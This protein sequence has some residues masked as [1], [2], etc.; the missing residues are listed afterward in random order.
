MKWKKAM[1][2]LLVVCMVFT[3]VGMIPALGVE[4]TSDNQNVTSSEAENPTGDSSDTSLS[5]TVEDIGEP[6]DQ[7]DFSP[8]IKDTAEKGTVTVN[9]LPEQAEAAKRAAKA[10]TA[11]AAANS[12]DVVYVS[13]QGNDD[14]GAGTVESPVATLSKAVGVASKNA[15][16]YV[17]SDLT[18][19]ESASYY[20]KNLTITSYNGTFTVTR[21]EGFAP[22]QDSARS[23]YNPAMIEVNSTEGPKTASLKL[24]NIVFDDSAKYEGEYF[25]QA[26]SE[27]DGHTTVGSKEVQNTAIVQDGIIATYNNVG[28]ITLG[29]G[30]VLKNYGGMSAVRIASGELIMEAGSQIIDEKEITRVKGATG[31]FGPAGAVW[32]QGGIL[33]MNGGVIGGA[34]N[35]V[36]T[37]RAVYV[38]GGTANV[39]GTLQNLKGTDAAWQGQNGVA[40][41]LRSG[42]EA[43]LASTGKINNVTGNNAGNNTAIWT[44][45]CNFTTEAGSLISQVNGFQMLHFDDLTDK[46]DYIHKVYL[47]GTISDCNSGSAC[48]LRSWY[49]LIELGENG[50]IEN[51]KT[52]CDGGLLYSNN[53]TH[54]IIR[55]TIRNNES[56]KVIFG[57]ITGPNAMIYM[58]NQ[59]GG[60]PECT[61]ESTARIIDNS[62]LG[63]RVNNG[64]LV[65]M[66]GGE[67]SGNSS[68]G[69][70]VTGKADRKGVKFIMNDG[71]IANNESYGISYT[72]AGESLVE[73]NGGSIYGNNG[74]NG[75]QISASGGYAVAENGDEAGYE[76]THIA[77]GVMNDSRRI[78][79]SA[80]TVILPVGYED[81]N[82]GRATTAAENEIKAGVAKEHADWTAIGSS[83]LWIQPSTEEYGFE[84]D[85]I[86]TVKKTGLYVAYIP[87][88]KDGTPVDGAEVI[89]E[90]VENDE[91]V[92]ITLKNLTAG[93]P[94][95]VMLFNNAEYIFNPDD[96][97]VY[98]GGGQGDE[99]YDDGFPEITLTNCVDTSFVKNPVTGKYGYDLKSLEVKGEVYTATAEESLLDQLIGLLKVS[100]TD[101]DGKPVEDD[102][103]AGE[104]TAKLSWKDDLKDEDVKVNGNEVKLGEGGSV[105]VRHIDDIDGAQNG[106]IT[107]E[108]LTEE[109]TQPVTHAEAIAK[110]G[111]LG[112]AP[113]FYTNNDEDREADAEGVQLLD[114]GLLLEEDDNRQE[115]M[116]QKAAE[117]L[118]APEEGRA[119]RYDFHYLDLVD[120]FNGNAWV[121]AQYGTTVYLPY[122][123]GVTKDNYKEL[124]V[125]VLH[126][127][128]LHREYGISGQ[129]DVEEAI[130]ACD[131]ETMEVEFDANGIKFDVPR[132]GF[133][134][135]AVIW[136]TEAHTITATAGEGGTVDPS[137]EVVVAEGADKT[138]TI[139][140]DKGYEIVEVVVDGQAVGLTDVVNEDGTGTYTFEKVDGDHSISITFEAI[141]VTPDPGEDEP[142]N[143]ADNPNTPSGDNQQGNSGD[144][145][146]DN[147]DKVQSDDSTKTGDEAPIALL[148]ILLI[149]SGTALVAVRRRR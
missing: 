116:E 148:A 97:T 91:H 54:Y 69:V 80:G 68:Y 79:V 30:A 127:K 124:D 8:V 140:P 104:Y 141:S 142:D 118:G 94:Y 71:I 146:Q 59:G 40:I 95:A 26:D 139:T 46:G 72:V 52:K 137:G 62:G 16:I 56:K 114:D 122:P 131:L 101:A 113:E 63:I 128:D 28:T 74:G 119:Y 110:Y 103:V 147:S 65:T 13:A 126:Y 70:Q 82:L 53:G 92:P 67:I 102:A 1:A 107:H 45:F 41:H 109:P 136:Q 33:N 34:D 29:E 143:P 21:G 23:T 111:N 39:G 20:G 123:E 129:A 89:I 31:S 76:Y 9:S 12:L 75:A 84:L 38:D 96:I 7:Q 61:I 10:P 73:V 112:S 108:L 86:S 99:N 58:A 25:V 15:T 144:N 50:V 57:S 4:N 2:A 27:G 24:S 135:F 77:K 145:Q 14:T 43:T 149:A 120:A 49:G 87:V 100:Y 117:Y 55:G 115:L 3:G 81:V 17:M 130:K 105:I 19:T 47:D 48:L 133:S 64:S 90:E 22:K 42:G 106:N 36:M 37:G 83:A 60:T 132:E 66:N 98:T 88:N 125:K 32:I 138:F 134:P 51:C 18:M 93:S 35:T 85:P 5:D 11:P 121:S 44:Q 6:E 78:S